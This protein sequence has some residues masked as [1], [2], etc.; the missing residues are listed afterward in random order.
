MAMP[1]TA[2]KACY[3]LG[4]EPGADD[5]GEGEGE[6]GGD[7]EHHQ[8]LLH[9]NTVSIGFSDYISMFRETLLSI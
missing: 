7:Q 4:L 2:G 9:F 6:A 1:V 8:T 3:E 5:E